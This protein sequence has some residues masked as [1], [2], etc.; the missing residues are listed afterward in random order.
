M[1]NMKNH[2]KLHIFSVNLSAL[3][4]LVVPFSL[5]TK[6]LRTPGALRF[7]TT[8]TDMEGHGA[9]YRFLVNLSNLGGLVVLFSLTTK[10]LRTLRGT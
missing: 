6:T 10:A 2:R 3:S 8:A 7:F 1:E 5:T 4:A 9:M